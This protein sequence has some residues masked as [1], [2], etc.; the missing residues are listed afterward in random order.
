MLS[1]TIA[2]PSRWAL[3]LA[4]PLV[5]VIAACGAAATPTPSPVGTPRP[6]PTPVPGASG[7]PAGSGSA[8]GGGAVGGG[9][10]VSGGN[11]GSGVGIFPIPPVP[12]DDPLV[13]KA[14]N[15][16][17]KAGRLNPHPVNVQLL[18]A[19]TDESG[20]RVELRWWSGVEECYATD[21]VKVERDDAA[22]TI[23]LTVMEGSNVGDVVCIEIAM[24]KSTVVDLGVLPAGTWTISAEGDAKPIEVEVGQPR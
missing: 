20:V 18:R 4:L 14:T 8:A 9:G 11:T 10:G 16:V 24:L 5:L 6:T 22:R 3:A 19:A 23:K 17:P 1:W 15:V 2:R 21:S 13:G 12:A 7:E